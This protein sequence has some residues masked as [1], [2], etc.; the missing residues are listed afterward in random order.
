MAVDY[1]YRAIFM[2]AAA[3]GNVGKPVIEMKRSA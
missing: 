3:F 1:G 2:S